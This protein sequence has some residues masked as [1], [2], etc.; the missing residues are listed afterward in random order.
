MP[1]IIEQS[2][3]SESHTLTF[4][5]LLGQIFSSGLS[6]PPPT[7]TVTSF[8]FV[9]STTN[10]TSRAV[11][12]TTVVV[13]VPVESTVI[14]SDPPTPNFISTVTATKVYTTT[15]VG[16]KTSTISTI[17]ESGVL[18]TS[19]SS[20]TSSFAR[21]KNAIIGVAVAS[22]AGFVLSI[23]VVF[24][25]CSRYRVRHRLRSSRQG[26]GY[27]GS[28]T[29]ILGY[30]Y[31]DTWRPPLSEEDV[32]DQ[33]GEGDGSLG[34]HER[35][36]G[37]SVLGHGVLGLSQ[38]GLQNMAV[39][40]QSP[41]DSHSN[42][43]DG[44]SG[45]G[46][47]GGGDGVIGMPD[48]GAL[49][50]SVPGMIQAPLPLVYAPYEGI[51]MS[52]PTFGQVAMAAPL[53]M[54]APVPVAS[55]ALD[56]VMVTGRMRGVEPEPVI[57]LVYRMDPVTAPV[58]PRTGETERRSGSGSP[59][60]KTKEDLTAT[61]DTATNMSPIKAMGRGRSLSGILDRFRIPV[62]NILPTS[63]SSLAGS[64]GV[65]ASRE[66]RM[67]PS[68]PAYDY[69]AIVRPQPISLSQFQR[70]PQQQQQQQYMSPLMLQRPHLQ[71]PPPALVSQSPYPVPS[72][73]E[74]RT[75]V[76]PAPD[77]EMGD[78]RPASAVPPRDRP[79]SYPYRRLSTTN[80]TASS[81]PSASAS[82]NLLANLNTVQSLNPSVP[83][84]DERGGEGEIEGCGDEDGEE[85]VN[86]RVIRDGLLDPYLGEWN[87]ERRGAEGGEDVSLRDYVDYSRRIGGLVNNLVRSTATFDTFDTTQTVHGQ[88]QL[89]QLDW[90]GRP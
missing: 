65:T 22:T 56:R 35:E 83:T 19:S 33:N 4:S 5:P 16:G 9:S 58:M 42:G 68:S 72:I 62:P 29:N 38:G 3:D 28:S 39:G 21:N 12:T 31:G 14:L 79:F 20:N 74:G 82:Q 87:V 27:D 60:G 30:G 80:G 73:S 69:G 86:V 49:G 8:S 88:Q 26:R 34:S 47:G 54:P 70:V 77:L 76:I 17:V 32:V 59:D 36:T 71:T 44:P 89:Q 78:G 40:Y 53:A 81:S 52:M 23:L 7:T 55:P 57:P 41:S 46:G 24:S 50:G 37:L 85:S 45:G 84:V 15:L 10:L 2:S 90:V 11:S 13:I 43:G 66:M 64:S 1:N 67:A 6:L 48:N 25:I 51:P 18:S 61:T 63:E 75:T